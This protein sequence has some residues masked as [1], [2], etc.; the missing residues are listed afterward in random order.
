VHE[1]GKTSI[2]AP[3]YASASDPGNLTSPPPYAPH[4]S[5]S[6]A[7]RS[8]VREA[9]TPATLAN[10]RK[11]SHDRAPAQATSCPPTPVH[12]IDIATVPRNRDT[13]V[14]PEIKG[15][16]ADDD[17]N[18]DDDDEVVSAPQWKKR[19]TTRAT[20]TSQPQKPTTPPRHTK[21]KKGTLTSTISYEEAAKLSSGAQGTVDSLPNA[22]RSDAD[23]S[24]GDE[25]ETLA[26]DEGDQTMQLD[27]D[28]CYLHGI[29][30][31]STQYK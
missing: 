7:L 25:G 15:S 1:S 30:E 10:E 29:A 18:D 22:A 8:A 19:R 23:A 26:P 31:T 24:D 11:R 27:D 20:R 6:Q 4:L 17:D 13:N 9:E 21:T 3:P 28:E 12:G 14:E 16:D 5:S 2:V